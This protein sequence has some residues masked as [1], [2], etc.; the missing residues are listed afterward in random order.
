[1]TTVNTTF[2]IVRHGETSWNVEHKVQGHEDIELNGKGREQ[3]I[4]L[5]VVLKN[6]H[7]DVVFSS[8]L[9]RARQTAEIALLQKNITI[10]TT[11]A[12]RERYFGRLQGAD[13]ASN[14]TELQ[15]LWVKIGCL[16]DKD[17]KRHNLIGVENDQD[18]INRFIPFLR[19]LAIAY[20]GKTVLI[21]T[22]SGLMRLLL[23]HIGYIPSGDDPDFMQDL[24][25]KI[26]IENASYI[27]LESDGVE[28]NIKE[29]QGIKIT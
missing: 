16:T 18:M 27:K 6:I 2:Y 19:E 25:K 8:D 1:M 5:G 10:Q 24:A 11:K 26:S 12:L 22:H 28:F 21:V 3:A 15:S 4:E 13:W 7:F 20:S 9:A 29:V 17:R 23:Y 14:D